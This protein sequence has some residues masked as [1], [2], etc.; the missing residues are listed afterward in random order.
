MWVEERDIYC[1]GCGYCLRGS[2]TGICPECGTAHNPKLSQTYSQHKRT[3]LRTAIGKCKIFLF[4]M[5]C[6]AVMGFTIYF[7]LRDGPVSYPLMI[8]AIPAGIA[9]VYA[10]I[11]EL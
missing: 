2:H 11:K 4:S 8:L 10:L 6:F 9:G 7:G 5:S 1:L 3:A